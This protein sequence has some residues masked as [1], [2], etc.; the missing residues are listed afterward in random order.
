MGGSTNK[1]A[2]ATTQQDLKLMQDEFALSKG[3]LSAGT[4]YLTTEYKAGGTDLLDPKFRAMRTDALEASAGSTGNMGDVGAMLQARALG[5]SGVA[6]QRLTAGLDEI[7]KLRGLLSSHGLQTTGLGQQG[8]GESLEALSLMPKH[9]ALST[10]LGIAAAGAGIYGGLKDKTGPQT[11]TI[12][13][14]ASGSFLGSDVNLIQG[15]GP[16]SFSLMGQGPSYFN[17]QAAGGSNG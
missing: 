12:A 13:P 5:Q 1:L 9:P 17:Y 3:A 2:E 14:I 10:G 8:Q 6:N 4:D 11:T 15:G 16:T 7:N